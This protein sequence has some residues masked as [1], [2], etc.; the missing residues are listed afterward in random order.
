MDEYISISEK[1][2]EQ[3]IRAEQDANRL[4][5]L[6]A[7]KAEAYGSLDRDALRILYTMFIG[8]KEEDHV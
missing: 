2:Y 7:E 5:A 8:E 3:L 6:I 1:R 4:K